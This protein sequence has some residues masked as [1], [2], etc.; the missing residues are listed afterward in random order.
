[1]LMVPLQA[2][3]VTHYPIFTKLM[4]LKDAMGEL[5]DDDEKLYKKYVR[6]IEHELLENAD[7]ICCTCIG[8]GDK[9]ISDMKFSSVLVDEATQ[10]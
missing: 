9:R 4:K 7:V 6:I 3:Q 8:A 5:K 1:M 10:V 2:R